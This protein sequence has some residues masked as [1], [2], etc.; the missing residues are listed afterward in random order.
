MWVMGPSRAL[1]MA[2]I[3][4]SYI[5]DLIWSAIVAIALSCTVFELTF[6]A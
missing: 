1:N 3:D 2:P 6:I 4:R 5:Y